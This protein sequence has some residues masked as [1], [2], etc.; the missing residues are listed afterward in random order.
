M[1]INQKVFHLSNSNVEDMK[2]NWQ[3]CLP[4]NIGNLFTYKTQ[5]G[6]RR[7]D[8][9]H[10]ADTHL[11]HI[12]NDLNYTGSD[13]VNNV[14]TL[15]IVMGVKKTTFD[16]LALRVELEGTHF[17]PILEV[18]LKQAFNGKKTFY[19]AMEAIR[20]FFKDPA[21]PFIVSSDGEISPVVAELF[22]LKWLSLTNVEVI[23]AFN[24]LAANCVSTT[25]DGVEERGTII[26]SSQKLSRVVQY[27]FSTQETESIINVIKEGFAI[28]PGQTSFYV[29]LGAG[30]EV[31]DFHP[32]NFR[33]II[34][35]VV[36]A[37]DP[38]P[39]RRSQVA[40][41]GVTYFDTS[42]PCPPFCPSTP[43]S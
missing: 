6:T 23:N 11:R 39:D 31:P 13:G 3:H 30:L 43:I 19:F 34:G 10:L 9:Y 42:K 2:L 26:F 27:T 22:I 1:R 25:A 36:E 32:F 17:V 29:H 28:D 5:T 24:G 40:V 20:D 7:Y 21:I 37:D 41:P 15:A 35:I 12:I 33:P 16:D 38:T 14:E 8:T 18:V 4:I